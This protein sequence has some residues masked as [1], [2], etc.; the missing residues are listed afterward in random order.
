MA[1]AAGSAEEKL[2]NMRKHAPAKTKALANITGNIRL[3]AHLFSADTQMP[4]SA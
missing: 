1:F 4:S 2:I 3:V